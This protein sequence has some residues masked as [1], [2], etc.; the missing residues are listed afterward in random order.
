MSDAS[1]S[2]HLRAVLSIDP[3]AGAIEF[4]G[5]WY[6]WGE[7]ARA[8]EA[9]E[10]LLEAYGANKEAAIGIMLRNRPPHIGALLAVLVS[11]R[12]T[13]TINPL[14]PVA[15]LL[16]D[17]EG[18]NL[19]VIIA[20]EE[21][22]RV[23]GLK[24]LAARQGTMGI[25][26]TGDKNNPAQLVAGL[27]AVGPQEH[28]QPTPGIAVEM[29]TSGTTGPPKR[30]KLGFKNLVSAISATAHYTKDS[31]KELT[32]KRSATLLYTPLVH[33]SGMYFAIFSAFEG[34]PMVL[35]ERFNPDKWR[36]AVKEHR[37][38]TAGLVPTAMRMLLDTDVP[39]EDLAS[40]LAV[41]SGTAPLDPDMADE[42]Q[43]KF[44]VPVLSTYGATEFA[45]AVTGW[46]LDLHKEWWSR[47]RGAAGRANKGCELRVVDPDD[48]HI[49]GANE[50]GLLEVKGDQIGPDWV[51]TADLA[52]IDEDEFLFITGRA[53]DAIIR[54]GFKI[55]PG[56]IAEI[57]MKHPAVRDVGIVG[58]DDTRLGQVPM[59]AIELEP[60]ATAP[61]IEEL[62]ELCRERLKPYEIPAQFLIVEA[63]PR[64]PS[65]KVSKLGVRDLFENEAKSA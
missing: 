35:L 56:E 12:C 39:K 57:I 6:T 25:S 27:E 50:V 4:D 23:P 11:E 31:Q 28:R 34:R 43:D 9:V 8:I 37:L 45:G 24:E 18:L 3:D 1:L 61:S 48:F 17:V 52:R 41:R 40:L 44:G 59:A 32:L 58:M 5:N 42:F 63:L 54:G 30:V 10:T 64:T 33:I 16:D 47:K 49:L 13:V 29:L 55:M 15:R 19:E 60:G 51:R 65:M 21:D 7:L 2:E 36:A 14:L 46:T 26:V 22:W 38:R 62:E 20:D 53:D